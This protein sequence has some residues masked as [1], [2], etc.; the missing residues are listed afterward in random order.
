MGRNRHF[1]EEE[2][3]DGKYKNMKRCS[4]SLAAREMP[5]KTTMRCPHTTTKMSKIKPYQKQQV[6]WRTRRNQIIHILLMAINVV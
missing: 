5:I 4:T 3:A 1:T 6:L 2:V